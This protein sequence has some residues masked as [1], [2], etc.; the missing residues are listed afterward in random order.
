MDL[1]PEMKIPA[2][3]WLVSP[4]LRRKKIIERL[5]LEIRCVCNRSSR[6]AQLD[7]F[8]FTWRSRELESLARR[9]VIREFREAYGPVLAYRAVTLRWLP[10][11]L[12]DRAVI[13]QINRE[14]VAALDELRAK[15]RLPIKK[16][17]TGPNPG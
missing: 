10:K 1:P 2:N 8:Q 4:R 12:N 3:L 13:Y 14:Y 16:S 15:L 9:L 6:H 7:N 11:S 5:W 17:S